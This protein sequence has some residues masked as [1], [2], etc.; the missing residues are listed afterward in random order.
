LHALRLLAEGQAVTSV[1]L[2]VGYQSTSAFISM[3]KKAMGSTPLRY[4]TA[5]NQRA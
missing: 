1:A 3:F 5:Y 4:R 2:E